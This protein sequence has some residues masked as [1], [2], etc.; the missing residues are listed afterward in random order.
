M[1]SASRVVVGEV[2][3]TIMVSTIILST[4][5][6]S[7][8]HHA[9]R[10]RAGVRWPGRCY[11]RDMP[12]TSSPRSRLMNG[13][14]RRAARSTERV[15]SLLPRTGGVERFLLKRW[16]NRAPA[17]MLDAYLVSGYQ[18]PRI[19]VQSIL[20]RHFLLRRL[21]G[22]EFDALMGQELRFAVE[23]NEILRTRAEELGVTMGAYL[24]PD[25]AADVQRVE[26]AIRD[27]ETEFTERWRSALDGREAEPLSVLELACGSANDYRTFVECGFARF[28]VYTGIDLTPKNISNARHRFPGVDFQVGDIS[29]VPAADGSFDYVIA[30][31][32]FEHLSPEAREQSLDE[33]TRLARRGLA[34]TFFNM[35]EDREHEIRTR[36]VYHWNRL[37]RPLIEERLRPAFPKIEVIPIASWLAS[38]LDFR[39]TYNSRAYSIFAERPRTG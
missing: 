29:K 1:I 22:D 11:R 18:N 39:H 5:T 24:D 13:V 12:S 32:I 36:R 16:W 27:R 15:A 10:V 8:A 3:P 7:K 37:S 30:S 17:H 38:Q 2:T 14:L 19:N 31:D 4:A 23:L 20:Q 9:S 21:F 6:V 26:D 28:L 35:S 34:L 25:K 33:A